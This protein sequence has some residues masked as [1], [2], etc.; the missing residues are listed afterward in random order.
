[1]E[2]ARSKDQ[3]DQHWPELYAE[4]RALVHGAMRRERKDHTLQPTEIVHE[5]YARLARLDASWTS[6][7]HVRAMAARVVREVLVDHARRHHSAKR[8]GGWR[9]TTM[10][11]MAS[12]APDLAIDVLDLNAAL[13][14]LRAR[15]PRQHEIV[16]CRVFGGMSFAEIGD[17]LGIQY[18][19]AEKQWRFARAWLM[20][21]LDRRDTEFGGG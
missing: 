4:L 18:D 2:S 1:M 8:G 7:G 17:A 16:V 10:V 3:L 12:L 19:S 13:E 20:R 11:D 14:K 9:R 21:E 5:A 15:R 6:S